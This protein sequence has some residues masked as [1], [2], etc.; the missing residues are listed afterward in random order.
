MIV[1][2][3]EHEEGRFGPYVLPPFALWGQQ[4][5]IRQS[6]MA[7]LNGV[8]HPSPW[9]D[10]LGEMSEEEY[11]C[12]LTTGALQAWFGV[13]LAQL[14]RCGF[15]VCAYEVRP[16]FVRRGFTQAV[17]VRAQAERVE[18]NVNIPVAA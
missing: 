3:V 17:F 11:S 10:G 2:R 6:T 4:E 18:T 16:E 14:A 12:F 1:Y 8:A 5:A 7:R 9:E 13:E 15:V